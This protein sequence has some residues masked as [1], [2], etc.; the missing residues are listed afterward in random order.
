MCT[1]S[2][3]YGFNFKESSCVSLTLTYL[4]GFGVI[5]IMY[6]FQKIKGN[7]C[8]LKFEIITNY[9]QTTHKIHQAYNCVVKMRVSSTNDSSVTPESK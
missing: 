3:I 7:R 2:A 4:S 5:F 1:R 6:T 8:H 9:I